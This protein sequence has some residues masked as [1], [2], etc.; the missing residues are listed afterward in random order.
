MYVHL[1]LFDIYL[2]GN[3][4]GVLKV[5]I[6]IAQLDL[7]TNEE[8]FSETFNFNPEDCMD[9]Y[10]EKFSLLSYETTSMIYNL[11]DLSII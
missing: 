9:E 7:Y 5:F 1:P 3:I 2:P 6:S 8:T 4:R 10:S 11:G